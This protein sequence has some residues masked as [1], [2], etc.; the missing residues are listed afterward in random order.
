VWSARNSFISL[1]VSTF[2]SWSESCLFARPVEN[3]QQPGDRR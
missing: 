2:T 3:N 1:D